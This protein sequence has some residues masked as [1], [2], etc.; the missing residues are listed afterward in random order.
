[1][2]RLDVWLT[3]QKL[4][5]S[6]Q[7]AKRAIRAGGVTVDGRIAKP[8]TWI[9]GKEE[10]LVNDRASNTPQGYSKLMAI[11]SALDIQFANPGILALD[12]GSSAGGFLIYLAEKGAKVIGLE[13]SDDF[14]VQLSEISETFPDV[15]ILICDAFEVDPMIICGPNELDL[16]LIDVT[17]DPNNTITLTKR[18]TPLLKRGGMIVAAL[19]IKPTNEE[20]HALQDRLAELGYGNIQ[21]VV[22]DQSRQEVHLIAIHQ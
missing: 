11:E 6:R 5:S 14:I 17:T 22:L 18:F 10:V 8:S 9:S 1:M 19:K 13:F 12:I 15:S 4:F 3:E 16:L 7:V 20:L 2:P 21:K